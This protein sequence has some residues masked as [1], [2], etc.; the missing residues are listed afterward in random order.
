MPESVVLTES[1]P[2]NS[3]FRYDIESSSLASTTKPRTHTCGRKG[4]R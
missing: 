2:V 3:D 1:V 4:P